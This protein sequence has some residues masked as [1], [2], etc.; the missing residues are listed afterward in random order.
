MHA[1]DAKSHKKISFMPEN[2]AISVVRISV[3]AYMVYNHA[4]SSLFR[5]LGLCVFGPLNCMTALLE[6]IYIHNTGKSVYMIAL[7]EYI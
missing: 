4:V 6:Y 5:L 1:H 3:T 2:I 7:L